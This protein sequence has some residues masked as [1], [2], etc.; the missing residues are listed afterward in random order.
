[1]LEIGCP[2]A[3]EPNVEQCLS[4]IGRPVISAPYWLPRGTPAVMDTARE[5]LR[6]TICQGEFELISLIEHISATTTP[7]FRIETGAGR[8]ERW[9]LRRPT[10]SCVW[11]RA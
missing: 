4:R 10:P 9:S 8:H 5:G 6:V 1:M 3:M 11:I 7:I 2:P